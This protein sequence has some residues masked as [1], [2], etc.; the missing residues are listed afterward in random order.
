MTRRATPRLRGVAA[1]FGTA[2]AITLIALAGGLA[3]QNGAADSQRGEVRALEAEL[4]A[5]EGQASAAAQAHAEAAMRAEQL[6]VDI[7]ENTRRLRQARRDLAT[8][9]QRLA[10]RLV[11][12]YAEEPPD[13]IEVLLTSGDLT[14]AV[15]AHDALETIGRS[16]QRILRTVR[17][18][19][20]RLRGAREELVASRVEVREAERAA[21]AEAQRLN[22]LLAQRRAVLGQAR[23]RLQTLEV[24]EEERRAQTR[25]I[26]AAQREGE[27][28]IRDQA[29]GGSPSG[30]G[31]PAGPA[32]QGNMASHLAR[33][34]QCESGGDPTAVSSSGQYRGKYQFDQQTW[35]ALGGSGDPAAAPVAEQDAR[36]A[37]L[38][39]ARGP[40]PW[41]VCG[42]L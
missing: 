22:G 6:E 16:D 27:A 11:T 34:A 13:F 2:G 1:A 31:A 12:I 26:A 8:S 33:I 17:A 23:A 42:R 9:Q 4:V 29:G 5:V 28:A 15:Q 24:A 35:E 3:A 20:T 21:A 32:P 30:G 25:A 7:K 19:R 18:S 36:A 14:D 37:A 10:D 41:P 39:Q 40:A 38:Y